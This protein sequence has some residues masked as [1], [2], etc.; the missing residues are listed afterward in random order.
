MRFRKTL[1]FEIPS[2]DFITPVYTE[3]DVKA[4][5]SFLDADDVRFSIGLKSTE[6][7][8]GY[9]FIGQ[10]KD[11][12]DVFRLG[13]FPLVYR[14]RVLDVL[15]GLSEEPKYLHLEL[16]PCI[17][18]K[19]VYFSMTKNGPKVFMKNFNDD[20]LDE[21]ARLEITDYYVKDVS[22]FCVVGYNQ[23]NDINKNEIFYQIKNPNYM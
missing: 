4:L 5:K 21:L 12:T 6:D 16:E 8:N 19:I 7:E 23:S 20:V 2:K 14:K 17:L 1:F 22:A 3:D 10:V 9:Y 13:D 11:F 18:K 15:K